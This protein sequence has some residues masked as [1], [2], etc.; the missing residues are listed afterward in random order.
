[1]LLSFKVSTTIPA[2]PERIYDAWLDSKAHSAMTGAGAVVSDKPGEDF[3]AWDG[4]ITGRNLELEPGRRILQTWRTVEFADDEPDS[5][6]EITFQVVPD[7]TLVTI[8][9]SD[10]PPHGMQYEQGWHES[11]FDPMLDYFED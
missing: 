6:L 9:H 2:S 5:R 10:L 1:M 3:Q 11:Y 8:H 4:Y 7:G